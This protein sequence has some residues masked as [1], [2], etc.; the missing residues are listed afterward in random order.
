MRTK[1]TLA[2]IVL[3]C[4]GA[5]IGLGVASGVFW[6]LSG[7][8]NYAVFAVGVISAYV[9]AVRPWQVRWGATD[10]EV[11][12]A[13]PGDDIVTGGSSTT[14]AITIAATASQIWPWLVQLGYG[15]AGWYSY[16]WI[17]NDGKP[18]A[19]RIVS[20]L[21]HL[22]VGQQIVMVP[23]LGPIV[24]EFE[25]D[26]YFVAGDSEAGTWCL[27]LYPIDGTHTRLVSRWR[28]SWKVTLASIFWIAI[29]DPGA[30]VME[31]KM[32]RGIRAR[33]ERNSTSGLHASDT[34]R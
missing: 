15:R 16:D 6:G 9:V 32:L 28:Q 19:G 21:Q 29:S 5:A 17:D 34:Y 10:D 7:L 4:V 31:R 2:T 33:A 24:R 30:F 25:P 20:E 22:E 27:A 11:G 1:I 23:G 8:L 18:S 3:A 13:M 26:Q 12:R 14:R